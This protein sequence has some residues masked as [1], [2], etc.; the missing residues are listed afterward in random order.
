MCMDLMFGQ[1]FR[2]VGVISFV[3]IL[4]RVSGASSAGLRIQN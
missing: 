1:G 2:S 3:R 4:K